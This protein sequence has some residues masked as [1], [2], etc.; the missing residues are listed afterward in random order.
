MGALLLLTFGF[1]ILFGIGFGLGLARK[2]LD[3]TFTFG[4]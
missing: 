1:G 2:I 4:R 3:G